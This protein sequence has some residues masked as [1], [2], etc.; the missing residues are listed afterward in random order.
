MPP[1]PVDI[2]AGSPACREQPSVVRVVGAGKGRNVV[3]KK[4]ADYIYSRAYEL[5]ASGLHLE[6]ITI[7][8]ALVN[9]GYAEAAEILDSPLI[10][11]DLQ[12]VC[13]C[14]WPDPSPEDK[15]STTENIS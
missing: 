10:R 7:I 15:P 5:A 1:V 12:Q 3:R 2:S 9:E 8:A 14:N 4:R 6:P 11:N 13:N